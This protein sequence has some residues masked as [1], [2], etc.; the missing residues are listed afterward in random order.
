MKKILIPEVTYQT[1][2]HE[3]EAHNL[4]V[5][6]YAT[7]LLGG[8]KHQKPLNEFMQ[9]LMENQDNIVLV[10]IKLPQPSTRNASSNRT[11]EVRG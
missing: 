10:R 3:G 9:R 2:Q 6:E 1:L 5:D 8:L 7:K 4:T 11:S